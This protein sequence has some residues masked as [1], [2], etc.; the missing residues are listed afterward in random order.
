[1]RSGHRT[2]VSL[3]YLKPQRYKQVGSTTVQHRGWETLASTLQQ[4]QHTLQAVA[5]EGPSAGRFGSVAA[6]RRS[7]LLPRGA[8]SAFLLESPHWA[9]ALDLLLEQAPH[10]ASLSMEVVRLLAE[11]RRRLSSE[12]TARRRER[13]A[14][15]WAW[16]DEQLRTGGGGL[17][18]ICREQ[19]A[20][21]I[22][23][24]KVA[25]GS[26]GVDTL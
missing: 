3:S 7:L 23:A 19:P 17:H 24:V 22:A 14:G 4:Y 18:A 25:G 16:C 5:R 9:L 2:R 1:M 6:F 20:A 15:Y 8:L 11:A 26:G 21:Q 13:C 12:Y 10:Y